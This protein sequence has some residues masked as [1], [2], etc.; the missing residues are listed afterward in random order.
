MDFAH[1]RPAE[2]DTRMDGDGPIKA[3]DILEIEYSIKNKLKVQ[4]F[5]G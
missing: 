3:S 5:E 4:I 1:L 2:P